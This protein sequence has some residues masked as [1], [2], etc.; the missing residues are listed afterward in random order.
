MEPGVQ[1]Y[2][3]MAVQLNDKGKKRV[4]WIERPF[5]QGGGFCRKIIQK[6]RRCYRNLASELFLY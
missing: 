4:K 1:K 3:L 6:N 5:S 2:H